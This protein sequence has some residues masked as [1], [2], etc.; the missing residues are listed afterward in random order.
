MS[1]DGLSNSLTHF[2]VG[3]TNPV[4]VASIEKV[5]AEH[6]PT[7]IVSGYEVPSGVSAQPGTDEET[8]LGAENRA[9][10][11][12]Q[13][14]LSELSDLAGVRCVGVGLEGGIFAQ[15]GEMWST[16]WCAVV[17]QAGNI[18]VSNGARLRVP[19]SI[20]NRIRSGEEMGHAVQ[21]LTGITNI[22][23]KHGMVGVI[24]NNFVDRT[25]EYSVIARLTIGLW[26][27]RNWERNVT[28][29]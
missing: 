13:K 20:A 6:W 15:K 3:S 29:S 24:T 5:A 14:G 2:F 21:N 27:G 11:A 12:L 18:F 8:R 9:K 16:V 17:D 22:K 25:S 7:A 28:R 26:F 4:K 19:D 23:Q 1:S 10:A